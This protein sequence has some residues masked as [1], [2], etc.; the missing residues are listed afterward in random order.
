MSMKD[1][2][3]RFLRLSLTGPDRNADMIIQEPEMQQLVS[4]IKNE[5]TRRREERRV[6]ELQW[7]MNQNYLQ[8]N[9]YCDILQETG[10]LIDYPALTED[11][12]RSVYNQIAPINETRLSKLSRVQPGLT[13]RPLTEDV[14]DITTART[15]TRLLKSAFSQQ[16]MLS[17]QQT[18]AAWAEICGCVFWKSTWDTRSGRLLGYWNDRAIYEGDISVSVVPAY[19]IFPANCYRQT[20]D[21]Q[22]SIIHARVY[23]V[24][25]IYNRW[26]ILLDGRELNVL[27]MESSGILAGGSGYNPSMQQLHD[28]Q[29]E[30]AE[31]VLEY[32]EK[33]SADFALGRHIIVAGDYVVHAGELP[34]QVGQ[35]YRRGYPFVQQFC[36]KTPGMFFGG[37]V[38]ERLIPLQRDYNATKNRINEHIARMS[39]NNVVVEQGSLVNEELLDVGFRP[40]MVV[41]YR[42]GATPPT[43][44]QVQEIPQTLFSKL[45]EMRNEFIDI[46]GVSEMSRTSQAPGSISSGTALEI[47]KE[48]DDTRLALTAENI[49]S[50]IQEV[51]RQWLRLF[52]QFAVAPRIT[53]IS[54]DDMGDVAT[55]IW[56]GSDITSDDVHVDTDNEMTNTPAQRKQMALDLINTGMFND[57]DTGAMTRETRGKLMEVFQLGNWESATDM[58]E[59]H[60]MRAQ[61]ESL[62]LEKRTLPKIMALDDHALHIKEHTRYALSAEFRRLQE[63]RPEMA[64][65]MLAHIDGHKQLAVEQAMAM[66]GAAQDVVQGEEM[67]QALNRQVINKSTNLSG[68]LPGGVAG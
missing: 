39:I 29:I 46:S 1:G 3:K 57:P 51:G 7:R 24:Q 52:K 64:V 37:T 6:F 18:A 32:Y 21:E 65:A 10:E 17:K 20:L 15:A 26:G 40:G 25:E 60:E 67:A 5:Y 23:T 33:P 45:T 11:E 16:Q 49:R 13:V 9:Q 55:L 28:N 53:R 58:D 66:Q 19:E 27:S 50:A 43:W 12:Q 62:E 59:L 35:Y 4:E 44:M 61:R 54:G 36:L 8:G 68:S 42:P 30:D 63:R 31:L 38:I 22:D 47:L 34:W 56:Q 41:E 48:Q 14:S 2:I